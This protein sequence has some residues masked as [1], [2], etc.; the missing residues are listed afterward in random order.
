MK[1]AIQLDLTFEQL[2]TMVKN[3][4]KAE[5]IR[6]TKELE[7]EIIDSKLSKLLKSF[8]TKELSANIINEEVE[9]VRQQIHEKKKH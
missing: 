5:K 6:L 3:L 7:K 1:T 9:I 2:L 8:R 4:P